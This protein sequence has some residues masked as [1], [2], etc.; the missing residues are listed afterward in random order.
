[1][2]RNIITPILQSS[3][4]LMKRWLEI[5]QKQPFTE[6]FKI[7]AFK[8]FSIFIGK[9]L[10][11]NLFLRWLLGFRKL[12]SSKKVVASCSCF[13]GCIIKEIIFFMEERNGV[14]FHYFHSE[15]VFCCTELIEWAFNFKFC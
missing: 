4:K 11:W 10:C 15:I 9:H 3:S 14:F 7:G 1:M 13:A 12:R 8:H 6:L 5:I 2:L